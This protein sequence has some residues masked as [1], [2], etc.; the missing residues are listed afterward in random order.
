MIYISSLA[1]QKSSSDLPATEWT[2]ISQQRMGA[3]IAYSDLRD[4]SKF[5]SVE[6]KR[7]FIVR[8]LRSRDDIGSSKTLEGAIR[9]AKAHL[10]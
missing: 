10:R 8:S 3:W 2:E 5:V 4:V 9:I 6:R 1:I 7:P